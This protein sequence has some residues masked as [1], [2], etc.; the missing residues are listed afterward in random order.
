M[1]KT[2][3]GITQQ[4]FQLSSEQGQKWLRLT[5]IFSVIAG[6]I[7]GLALTAFLPALTVLV[8]K[9]DIWGL[10]IGGWLGVLLCLGVIAAGVE[11]VLAIMSYSVALD[12]MAS[13]HKK[14][15]DQAARLPLGYFTSE[16]A[17][18]FSRL[19]SK[20]MIMLGE[21]FAHMLAPMIANTFT[22]LILLVG[23]WIWSPKMGILLT[24]SVPVMFVAVWA[25]KRCKEQD[26]T[27][28]AAPSQELSARLVEFAQ[29]QPILRA[30]GQ[31]SSFQPLLQATRDAEKAG[32]K[33]LWWGLLGNAIIGTVI[34]WIAVFSMIIA[35]SATFGFD[36]P[37][38]SIV[39]IG[40]MLR[41]TSMLSEIGTLGMGLESSRPLL[42]Q[43]SEILNEPVLVDPVSSKPITEPGAVELRDVSFGYTPDTLVLQKVN[44]RCEPNSFTAIVGP[45][46]S[47]K[48]TLARLIARFYEVD[49]GSVLV[50]GVAVKDQRVADVMK[51]IA[52]IF[53]DVYLYDDTLEANIRVGNPDA[54][55]EQIRQAAELAGVTEIVRRLPDGWNTKVGEGGRALS[56]GE[57][58]RVSIARA[59]LK[60]AAIV[61]VDE[62]T[63]ALDPANEKHIVESLEYLRQRSTLIVIAHKLSTIQ[64]ADHIVVLDS[65]GHVVQQ[66]THEELLETGGKYREFWQLRQAAKGWSLT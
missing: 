1:N 34:Q 11:Y 27:I 51:Q 64:S 25:A 56:G 41:F 61:L 62:A 58:Q 60:Q 12:A 36:D 49:Q 9:Q 4:I 29:K 20:Q 52:W 44:M 26:E 2:S 65:H 48:T 23:C 31:A 8:K 37:I 57:R 14:I 35:V 54:T 47:G 18:T 42:A 21:S 3:R 39:F 59:I 24:I 38:A 50:G 43:V 6:I 40:I 16:T 19:V 45:S 66:G 15:G 7:R 17:G 30:C 28:N 55:D 13:F 46:G 32:M 33:G 10:G 63:S 5:I 22:M 53:Q